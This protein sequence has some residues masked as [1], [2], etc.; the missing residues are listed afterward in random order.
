MQELEKSELKLTDRLNP[1]S[2]GFIGTLGCLAVVSGAVNAGSEVVQN[3]QVLNCATLWGPAAVQ[4]AVT[5]G[6]A[7]LYFG[8]GMGFIVGVL[9]RGLNMLLDDHFSESKLAVPTGVATGVLV[10]GV[11]GSVTAVAVR[12]ETAVGQYVGPG[13]VE[14]AQQAA[15][16]VSKV[17]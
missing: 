16:Y 14:G 2:V 4:G 3:N 13:L 17:F 7:A 1:A 12:L 9:E 8:V 6:Y 5:G 11:V 10:G 15:D